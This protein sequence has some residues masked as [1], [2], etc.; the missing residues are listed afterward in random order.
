MPMNIFVSYTLQDGVLDARYLRYIEKY[1]TGFGKPYIDLFHN[2]DNVDPQSYVVQ[3]LHQASVL[4]ALITPDF[5]LSKWTQLELN[6]A[7]KRNIPIL[8]LDIQAFKFANAPFQPIKNFFDDFN[9]VE[10]IAS[11]SKRPIS[12]NDKIN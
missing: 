3:M 7:R 12:C 2:I 6:T 4:C 1:L 9:S 5:Y 10:E 11:V 8:I